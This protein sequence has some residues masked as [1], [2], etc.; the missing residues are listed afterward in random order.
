MCTQSSDD[1]VSDDVTGEWKRH[2][3]RTSTRTYTAPDGSTVTEVHTP[4][5][6]L[7]T[8]PGPGPVPAMTSPVMTSRAMTSLVSA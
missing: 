6:G 4:T 5:I 1:D 3:G 7:H 8:H 2:S